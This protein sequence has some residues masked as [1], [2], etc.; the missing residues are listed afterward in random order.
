MVSITDTIANTSPSVGASESF[1]LLQTAAYGQVL[2]GV[3]FT[4]TVPDGTPAMPWQA[5]VILA[6]LLMGGAWLALPRG[7]AA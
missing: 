6:A 1:A 5:L 2:R 3:C 4:P 7:K